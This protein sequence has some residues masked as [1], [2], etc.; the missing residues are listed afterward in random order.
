MPVWGYAIQI[1]K[2]KSCSILLLLSRAL[3]LFL[4]ISTN[5]HA[6]EE[7]KS[8]SALI[9]G[10]KKEGKVVAYL[11]TNL[12]E[13]MPL[14]NKFEEQYP[15]IKVEKVMGKGEDSLYKILAEAKAKKYLADVLNGKLRV[16]ITLK[17]QGL[18]AQ[19]MSPEHKFYPES[20]KD[21]EGFWST[22]YLSTFIIGYNTKLVKSQEVP[23]DYEALL[24]PKWKGKIGLDFRDYDWFTGMLQIMGRTKGIAYM[25]KLS[26]QNPTL[27]GS[28]SLSAQLL[29]AGE[30]PLGTMYIHSIARMKLKGAPVEWAK[31]DA[32]APTNLT[33]LSVLAKAPH[34]N[35]AR[36]FYNFLLSKEAQEILPTVGRLPARSGIGLSGVP[37]DF[38]YFVLND[39]LLSDVMEKNMKEFDRI[40]KKGH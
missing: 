34:P 27:R 15:F 38:K 4:T 39:A 5:A 32:P 18:L 17:A 19:Y 30:Y 37:K 7:G 3:I 31:F 40:F 24:E 36:L 28:Q 25:E 26:K 8:L 2:R 11:S 10:A 6:T 23:K 14:I 20:F 12:D 22:Q 33:S 35:A 16:Q 1:D 29:A 9:E 21:P 13:S